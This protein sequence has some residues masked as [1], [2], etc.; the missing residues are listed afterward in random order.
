[1]SAINH[2]YTEKRAFDTY[3]KTVTAT[4]S[5]RVGRVTDTF[6]FDRVI[7]IDDP[8]SKPTI[9]V[10]DGSYIGQQILIVLD[11]DTSDVDAAVTY[12]NGD[13]QDDLT[14][15]GDYSQAIWTGTAWKVINE[16][17]T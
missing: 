12:T 16:L 1:M 14:A 7:K 17:S 11:S 10:P 4:Y 3:T 9:T 15:A 2:F 5:A 8:A 6:I 13:N